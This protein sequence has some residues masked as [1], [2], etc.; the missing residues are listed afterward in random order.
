MRR[1]GRWSWI[2]DRSV[3]YRLARGSR[4]SGVAWPWYTDDDALD[5]VW[6]LG[7]C[8]VETLECVFDG[9]GGTKRKG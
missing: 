6:G 3:G 9:Y 5:F 7:L 8:F 2:E 1:V 4:W